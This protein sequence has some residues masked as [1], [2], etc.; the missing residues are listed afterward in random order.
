M[1]PDSVFEGQV[2]TSNT[3]E[4]VVRIVEVGRPCLWMDEVVVQVTIEINLNGKI[5][6]REIG[7]KHLLEQLKTFDLTTEAP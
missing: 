4:S 6:I 1:T 3:S 2:W 5:S 7:F